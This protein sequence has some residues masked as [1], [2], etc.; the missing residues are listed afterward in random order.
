MAN[1]AWQCSAQ[2]GNVQLRVARLTQG[3]SA[4]Q[5][6]KANSASQIIRDNV[7]PRVIIPAQRH[8]SSAYVGDYL[9]DLTSQIVTDCIAAI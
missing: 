5:S 4:A 6:G 1:S 3:G 2:R 8:K 9:R 7:Q